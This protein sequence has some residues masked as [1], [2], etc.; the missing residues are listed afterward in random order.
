MDSAAPPERDRHGL[1]D[2][3][4][5]RFMWELGELAAAG[6]DIRARLFG[7]APRGPR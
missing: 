2:P 6:E 4:W 7:P 3:D 5:M 1:P